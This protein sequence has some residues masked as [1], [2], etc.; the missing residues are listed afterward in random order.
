MEPEDFTTI[1]DEDPAVVEDLNGD[2]TYE[3][4]TDE[5]PAKRRK[6]DKPGNRRLCVITSRHM[7]LT[8]VEYRGETNTY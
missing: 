6:A 8:C 2:P 3:P 5:P 7:K 1:D 4:Q